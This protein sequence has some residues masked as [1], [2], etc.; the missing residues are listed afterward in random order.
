MTHM[1]LMTYSIVLYSNSN[2]LSFILS[3]WNL[4]FW[5][6][7]SE[8]INEWIQTR[9]RTQDVLSF[10]K[11]QKNLL[12]C[13]QVHG[14]KIKMLWDFAVHIPSGASR[15][16]TFTWTANLPS[17]PHHDVGS[18][19]VVV[20]CLFPKIRGHEP[21]IFHPHSRHRVLSLSGCY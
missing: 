3:N 4:C 18:G 2:S 19:Q 12:N 10:K 16:A 9:L 20:S 1:T 5:K 7:K 6:L 8:W 17:M 14:F 15:L 21:K 11:K 13:W